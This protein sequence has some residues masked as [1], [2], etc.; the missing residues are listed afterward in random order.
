MVASKTLSAA[1]SL[2]LLGTFSSFIPIVKW[3]L[4]HLRTFQRGFLSQWNRSSLS[5]KILITC[6][7]ISSLWWWTRPHNL[8]NYCHLGPI[9]WTTLTSDASC[10]GWGAHFT[11]QLVQG[12]WQFNSEGMVSNILE[13]RAAWMAMSH[14]APSLRG[15]SI[16]LQM[17]NKSAVAYVQNRGGTHSRS[18]SNEVA[19][20]ILWAEENLTNLTASF[21]PA[22]EN[23]DLLGDYSQGRS[24]STTMSDP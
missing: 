1:N 23:H 15:K 9:S 7:M 22:L 2:S 21:M 5:Q 12:K 3:A 6:S 24:S 17:D 16:L 10:L 18:L 11:S 4:W 20:I 8:L 19:P 13:I 14:L